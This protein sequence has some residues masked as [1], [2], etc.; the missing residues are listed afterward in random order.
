MGFVIAAETPIDV[1]PYT[2]FSHQS[3]VRVVYASSTLLTSMISSPFPF[4]NSVY[5][6]PHNLFISSPTLGHF[7]RCVYVAPNCTL[8]RIFFSLEYTHNKEILLRL[9]LWFIIRCYW[10]IHHAKYIIRTNFLEDIFWGD[11]T[12]FDIFLLVVKKPINF[13]IIRFILCTETNIV[14]CD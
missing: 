6:P 11:W 5:P 10:N 2:I 1:N 7:G 8:L 12:K 3:N 9:V 13:V 4:S 14:N